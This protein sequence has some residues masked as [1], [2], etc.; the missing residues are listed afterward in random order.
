MMKTTI[1]LS[2]H[3]AELSLEGC[4]GSIK[5]DM[6]LDIHEDFIFAVDIYSSQPQTH[7]DN[8]CGWWQFKLENGEHSIRLNIDLTQIKKHSLQVLEGEEEISPINHW[9]NPEYELVPLMECKLVFWNAK[10]EI[11]T[12]KRVLLKCKNTEILDRFYRKHHELDA[13]SPELP[14]LDLLHH[15]KLKILKKYFKKYFKGHVLDIGCGLSLFTAY[16]KKDWPFQ[17]F[18]GDIVFGRMKE[19]RADRPDINWVVFDASKL[20]FK[21]N[22]FM[23]LFAGEILEHLPD[24]ES[25]L[26][27]WN[28]VQKKNGI[29]IVTTPNRRRRINVLNQQDWPISPDHLREFS[30]EEL[31][32]SLLP[33]NG[34]DVVRKRGLYLELWTKRRWW[35]EDHLQREGNK[36]NNAWL[37]RL[38]FRLGYSFPKKA[39]GLITVARKT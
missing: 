10:D 3:P 22:S 26:Q 38:L 21:R 18:A 31:N 27:E 7:P 13:Y 8:H 4:R 19:R 20:P 9:V 32:D 28:R 33:Q 30:F 37:M 14:F 35:T 24:P 11:L 2:I 23:S 12:L 5:V 15:Y 39:F 6:N 36:P 29:L 25:A 34:Y 16:R 1:E 17:I